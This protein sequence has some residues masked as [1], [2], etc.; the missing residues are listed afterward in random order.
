MSDVY[1]E[2]FA[3]GDWHPVDR[4]IRV[5]GG[6]GDVKIDPVP[7]SKAGALEVKVASFLRKHARHS[8][9]VVSGNKA[10]IFGPSAAGPFRIRTRAKPWL[11]YAD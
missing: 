3:G 5:G 2:V 7:E 1:L 10:F 11:A 9:R 4:L 6:R 8:L